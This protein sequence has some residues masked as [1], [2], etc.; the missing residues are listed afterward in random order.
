MNTENIIGHRH[1]IHKHPE[2]PGKEA[3]TSQYIWE[4][5][6]TK[7]GD[8]KLFSLNEDGLLVKF[9]GKSEHKSVMLRCELDALA[10]QE[11]NNFEYRSIESNVSHKCGHDGH[12][13]ILLGVG[14][15]LQNNKPKGDVYLLFQS[16]E[17]TGEGAARV[18]K[19]TVFNKNCRPEFVFALH[20]IP[21][22]EMHS[23]QVKEGQFTPS[24]ISVEI[25][26]NGKTAHAAEPEKG[27]NPSYAI[28]EI[29][30]EI[31]RLEQTNGSAFK[32]VTPIY[33]N[34]GSKDF[35]VSAG[36]G[37][38]GFTLRAST[39]KEMVDLKDDFI[40][41]IKD[42]CVKYEVEFQTQWTQPFSSITNDSD[43]V[44]IIKNAALALELKYI[45]LQDAFKWGEDFGLFTDQFKG[46]MFGL[47]SG[48]NT[49]ALHNPD[50]DF[51]DELL[52]TGVNMFLQIIEQI[53][54]E[55][56]INN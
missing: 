36:A 6:A 15:H 46:A 53:Q 23:V 8:A 54:D 30:N 22:T 37:E 11:I 44:R 10:I 40:E 2:L 25:K 28:A 14:I 29:L 34:V 26:L 13:A 12:M 19:N 1:H 52:D 56:H 5:F 51:P 4:F 3:K 48:I 24:V 16:A 7:C 33:T 39:S 35:G 49:P 32:Q 45:K 41:I 47:G 43:A 18:I 50:Y 42:L 38:M 9:E 20:N 27:I 55:K 31:K 17:E 21:G